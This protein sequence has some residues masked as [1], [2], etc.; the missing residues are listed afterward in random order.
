MRVWH[1][2]ATVRV[3]AHSP[4][5]PLT[6]AHT[7][8]PTHSPTVVACAI[9]LFFLNHPPFGPFLPTTLRCVSEAVSDRCAQA[10]LRKIN[11]NAPHTH[12][13]MCAHARTDLAAVV[14]SLVLLLSD[15]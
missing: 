5:H 4:T 14:L 2:N 3:R 15:A 8:A 10:L 1:C 11:H 13:H 6:H 9:F 7:Q 12:T